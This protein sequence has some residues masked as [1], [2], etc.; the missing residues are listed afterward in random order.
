MA[1]TSRNS[2]IDALSAFVDPVKRL[3]A[4]LEQKLDALGDEFV[5][6][7]VINPDRFSE[8]NTALLRV[9]I[10]K[11][12]LSGI[13]ITGNR[14]F[15]SLMKRL[16][17]NGIPTG[18]IVFIDCVSRKM[19]K[20]A[21]AAEKNVLFVDSLSDLSS[22]T[23][24]LDKAMSLSSSKK[25]FIVLDSIST[26]SIYHKPKTVE[27]FVHVL[28]S[29]ISSTPGAKGLFIAVESP[30]DKVSLQKLAQFCDKV[31]RID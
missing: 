15:D 1:D 11:K 25:I 6:L 13:Y 2:K 20:G 21:S 5:S 22:L 24:A 3:S 12:G 9:L 7:L 16:S 19:G 10:E 18:G 8:I 4:D 14:P 29:R 30:E 23:I 27:R 26:L 31:I 28:A 17:S